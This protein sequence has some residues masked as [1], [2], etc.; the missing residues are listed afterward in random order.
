MSI[1]D[2]GRRRPLDPA[3]LERPDVKDV[4]RITMS[5]SNVRKFAESIRMKVEKVSTPVGDIEI[6]SNKY[7]PEDKVVFQ[8]RH[9]NLLWVENIGEDDA[10]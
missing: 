8:D 5:E 10:G 6:V 7:M 2:F 4:R 9:G 1:F 3:P